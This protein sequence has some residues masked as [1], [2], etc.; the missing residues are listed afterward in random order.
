MRTA[1]LM[2]E[3]KLL[4][5]IITQ[6]E[7]WHEVATDFRPELF[8]DPV[9]RSIAGIMLELTDG[10]KRPSS[11]QL[12]KA[13]REKGLGI[14]PDDLIGVLSG[15]VTIR[16][17]KSLMSELEDLYKRRTVY[18][19]LLAALDR[20]QQEDK[21]TD[22]L[23]AEA[24]Q[25]MIDAFDKTG[26]SEL[27]TMHHVA[28][29]LFARQERIQAGEEPPTYPVSLVGL[30]TL[31][32]GFE[33]GSLNIVAG[34][35]SMGKTSF[36]LNEALHWAQMGLPGIIF[37]LEQEDLQI[38]RRNLANLEQMPVNIMRRKMDEKH[39]DK[40]YA[41][42]SKLRDLPIKI[43]D[44]RGLTVDQICS[45]SRVEKM[46]TANL[47]WIG[48]DY[49]TMI[50]LDYRKSHHLAIGDAVK[51]LRDLAGEL[52]V[53]IVLLSQLNRGLENRNDKRPTMPDLRE[54]GAIEES[55]DT[56]LFLYREGY[57]N[58]DFLGSEKGDWITEIEVA[59]NREGGG[60]GRRALAMFQ[61]PYMHWI[62][63]PSDLA[64]KYMKKVKR[65]G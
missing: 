13:F 30:Q 63:C 65:N 36:L 45:L 21:E 19:T 40:F 35:P 46:R 64:E 54:S 41:G 3:Q 25:A 9:Y 49:L 17:T 53:F 48:I 8:S 26:R 4:G 33:S 2:V 51:K 59:K 32:G 42:L 31:L 44:R 14:T 62:D 58:P 47:R 6:P 61:Q 27:K 5:N 39:L 1:N 16:E 57:Y 7:V 24:Q 60:A 20:L 34:R 55:A 10:G 37:S 56:I 52:D 29:K 11:V 23:I 18:Q 38:G 50:S 43:S 15:H 22:A 28:E 12:Y